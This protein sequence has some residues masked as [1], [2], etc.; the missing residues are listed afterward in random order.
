MKSTAFAC[1]S[2]EIVSI[3]TSLVKYEL[4]N[5]DWNADGVDCIQRNKVPKKF[6]L[7]E[8]YID[9][10]M[11]SVAVDWQLPMSYYPPSILSSRQI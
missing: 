10:D 11:L 5:L 2:A 8:Q 4:K 6:V 3:A 1:W 7:L 9:E